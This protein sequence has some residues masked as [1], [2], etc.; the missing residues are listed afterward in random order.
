MDAR[1]IDCFAK[2]L[3]DIAVADP[4]LRRVLLDYFTWTTTT[5]MA[6]YPRSRQDVPEGLRLPRWSWTGLQE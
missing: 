2:A 4:D 3:D 6:A 5:T 1:A